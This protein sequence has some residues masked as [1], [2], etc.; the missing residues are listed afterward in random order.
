MSISLSGLEGEVIELIVQ[1]DGKGLPQEIDILNTPSLG[2][3]LA[4]G[5]VTRELG[6]SIEVERNGG[7]RFIIRFKCKRKTL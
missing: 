1:D 7:T 3:R 4:A 6:G 5:A 2:L